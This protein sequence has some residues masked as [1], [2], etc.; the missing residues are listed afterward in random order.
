MT[1]AVSAAK[2]MDLS[3]VEFT[4]ELVEVW[5]APPKPARVYTSEQARELDCAESSKT[6]NDFPEDRT[7]PIGEPDSSASSVSAPACGPE[8]VADS[9]LFRIETVRYQARAAVRNRPCRVHPCCEEFAGM[10]S[11]WCSACLMECLLRRLG[12][13]E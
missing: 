8:R 5:N 6:H 12:W 3:F 10:P 13:A 4:Q 1:L 7:E 11:R 9:G 2:A